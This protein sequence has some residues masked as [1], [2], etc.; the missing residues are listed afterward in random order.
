MTMN[1]QQRN[2][3]IDSCRPGDPEAEQLIAEHDLAELATRSHALDQMMAD[4]LADVEIPPGLEDRLLAS[5]AELPLDGQG[6]HEQGPLSEQSLQDVLQ[7]DAS[8][9]QADVAV[10]AIEPGE[11]S[12]RRTA[13]AG[14]VMAA[15]AA[16]VL[17]IVM[18]PTSTET[19]PYPASELAGRVA[20]WLP[21][22]ENA[23]SDL[24]GWQQAAVEPSAGYLADRQVI[25]AARS[26]RMFSTGLDKQA[27]VWDLSSRRDGEVYLVVL[28]PSERYSLPEMPLRRLTSS[29][30]WSLGAWQ[31]GDTLYVLIGGRGVRSLDRL[32]R[33]PVLG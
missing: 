10:G 13:I 31:T 17:A 14:F 11:S 16:V 24:A 19:A 25:P 32:I 7:T 9:P 21:R 23:I 4:A 2:Q 28:R 15:V 5:L 29:G 18:R 26:W 33:Q 8:G 27:V 12:R 6:R 30:Q 20:Q 1:E 3:L 22:L